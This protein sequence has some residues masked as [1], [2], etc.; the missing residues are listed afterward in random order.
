[1]TDDLPFPRNFWE[2]SPNA[3]YNTPR[4]KGGQAREIEFESD[5]SIKSYWF[6]GRVIHLPN[7]LCKVSL[8]REFKCTAV[9]I[10]EPFKVR[11]ITKG[12]AQATYALKGLQ[13]A[14]WTMMK[15]TPIFSLI[16]RTVCSEDIPV[17]SPGEKYLSGDFSAATDNLARWCSETVAKELALQFD[18][19]EGLL[20]SSLCDNVIDYGS[21]SSPELQPF[22]QMNGQLM[23]SVLSF[24][25]LNIVNAAMLWIV[26]SPSSRR[27][28]SLREQTFRVNG[29]DSVSASDRDWET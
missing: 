12:P 20:I 1:M 5:E 19:P 10:L 23:G 28:E 21:Y 22:K 4:S 7:L 29:D 17:L 9:P 18:L 24:L 3:S 25:V 2:P 26:K 6:D 16:G 8:E 11:V 14:L 15:S 27:Q 13:L